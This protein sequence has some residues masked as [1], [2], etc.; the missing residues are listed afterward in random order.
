MVKTKELRVALEILDEEMAAGVDEFEVGRRV[1]GVVRLALGVADADETMAAA[2]AAG[3]RRLGDTRVAPW[4][5]R[6][7]RVESPAGMQLTLF[8]GE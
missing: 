8:S 5:D 4:G 1:S 2:L 3:A 7:G 6:L